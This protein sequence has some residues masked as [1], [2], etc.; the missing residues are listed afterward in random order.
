MILVLYVAVYGGLLA[1]SGGMPYV[2]DNNESFSDFWHAANLR[3]FGFSNSYG[4]TDESYGSNAAAH[5]YIYTHQGNFPRLFTY[6]ISLLGAR[7]VYAQILITTFTVGIAAIAF[8]YAF[9]ARFISPLF[10]FTACAILITDYLL[11]AQWQVVT[12]RV[13]H[14]FFLF[15]SALCVHAIASRPRCWRLL[16]VAN[17]CCLFYFELVF[18]TFV[19]LFAVIYSSLL[20]GRSS[21]TL[22]FVVW[23]S[24]GAATG[25]G[26]FIA[27]LVLLLGLN[28]FFKDVHF[29]F[30]SRNRA[31]SDPEARKEIE[32]FFDA[33]NIVFWYNWFD[34]SK[35]SGLQPFV[36]SFSFYELQV[37]TPWLTA[38]SG[39]ILLGFA[40]GYARS[41]G[42]GRIRD[43]RYFSLAAAL[44]VSELV[45]RLWLGEFASVQLIAAAVLMASGLAVAV[46]SYRLGTERSR[47]SN[48]I[49][50]QPRRTIGRW[51]GLVL[52]GVAL[53]SA[54]QQTGENERMAGFSK[55]ALAHVALSTAIAAWIVYTL[56][57]DA[58]RRRAAVA[59]SAV[60]I[61]IWTSALL[62]AALAT[63]FAVTTLGQWAFGIPAW[64][65]RSTAATLAAVA[66]VFS[67]PIGYIWGRNKRTSSSKVSPLSITFVAGLIGAIAV[68]LY[69][70]PI[71]YPPRY[72]VIWSDLVEFSMP[73]VL[74]YIG[75]YLAVVCAVALAFCKWNSLVERSGLR[76][77][78]LFLSAGLLSY[79]LVFMLSP[80]YL[81]TG[82]R[83]RFVPFS[84][85]HTDALFAMSFFVLLLVIQNKKELATSMGGYQGSTWMGNWP[86]I[87]YVCSW[88]LLLVMAWSW[89]AIQLRY[90]QLFPPNH[91]D[92][93]KMLEAPP[94]K[95]K[96]FITNTYAAPIAAATG[97]WAYMHNGLAGGELP[98]EQGRNVIVRDDT[99]LWLADKRENSAYDEPDFFI[100]VTPPAW[101]YVADLL[102]ESKGAAR[103]PR[104][105]EYHILVAAATGKT[106]AG[107]Y[108]PVELAAWDE[109][110]PA[111]VGYR[112]WA[113]VKLL[114]PKRP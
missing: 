99:Y 2:L 36:A 70:S 16:V 4:V 22:S 73:G 85:F 77:L 50:D 41:I 89:G 17:F 1:T 8:A 95:R 35:L 7:T 9:F 91:Y 104:G 53:L 26:I 87:F 12:Y 75:L 66:I 24:L 86:R 113:I 88:M 110:G 47:V 103:A 81:F 112:R 23:S 78:V 6:L 83:F 92:F 65:H 37:H 94:Y 76:V 15:S 11:V 98:F 33:H 28:D 51:M 27:Q 109:D 90:V 56:L 63:L 111:H 18:A 97:T 10:A 48:P 106:G 30:I 39:L 108:P 101:P 80:G 3:Q 84:V 5:P 25:V 61:Y 44:L 60:A 74:K 62:A 42:L 21:K 58:F 13:W 68:G 96:S 55:Y 40:I 93:L 14:E 69:A 100:C 105:C 57:K 107:V 52:L 19:F 20:Y 43:N 38:L 31:L 79:L 49:E 64:T 45:R 32:R 46:S 34:G 71:L 67:V 102:L 72:S 59:D 82:Y 114:W 29:T 54:L